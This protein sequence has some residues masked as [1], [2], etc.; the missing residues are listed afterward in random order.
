[1]IDEAL[2]RRGERQF[3]VY[4]APCHGVFGQGETEVGKFMHTKPPGSLHSARARTMGSSELERII[5]EG[6]G[7]MPGFAAQLDERSRWAAV[8]WVKLLQRSYASE[9]RRR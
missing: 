9:G 2:L 1:M 6:T 7:R 8:A 4:C 5:A 3:S